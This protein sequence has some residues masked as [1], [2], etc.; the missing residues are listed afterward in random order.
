MQNVAN[1]GFMTNTSGF[2]NELEMLKSQSLSTAAVTDLKLYVNYL[3]VSKLKKHLLYQNQPINVDMDL[4]HLNELE[5]PVNVK[6]EA[7]GN[8]KYDIS[9]SYMYVDSETEQ[10]FPE[11]KTYS[12]VSLPQILRTKVG[13]ITITPNGRN[14]ISMAKIKKIKFPANLK[15][16]KR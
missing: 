14:I 13:V 6:I 3:G 8:N 1:L 11:Q 7:A 12:G 5:A 9:L 16:I 10:L 15:K 2:D 4:D